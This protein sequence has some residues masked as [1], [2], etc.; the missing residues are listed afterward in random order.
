MIDFHGKLCCK[1]IPFIIRNINV[2]RI[3]C[4]ILIC[5]G[6]LKCVKIINSVLIQEERKTPAQY[7]DQYCSKDR[8]SPLE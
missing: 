3:W 6:F 5:H 4:P 7:S 1:I 2:D 8:Q